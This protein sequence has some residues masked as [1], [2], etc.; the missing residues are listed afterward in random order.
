MN[1]KLLILSLLAA[2]SLGV[3]ACGDKEGGSDSSGSAQQQESSEP[4][5]ITEESKELESETSSEESGKIE[6]EE[7]IFSVELTIPADFVGEQTQEDLDK[8]SEENGFK[9][10]VLN[11]DGSATYTMTKKQHEDM[12]S[13]MKQQLNASLEELI[14]S[15]DYPNFTKIE[16]NDNFTEFT[17][18]TK[19][20][21]LDMA[22]SFSV[23]AFYMYGGMY[24]VFSGDEV[25]NINV[26]FINEST[27]KLIVESNSKDLQSSQSGSE[28]KEEKAAETI[29][30]VGDKLIE[31]KNWY[32][33]KIWNNFVDFD[34]YRET[35]K[36]C[37]G[38][39][40]DI[41]FAYKKFLEAY[42]LKDEYNSYIDLLS[43]DYENLKSVWAKMDEQIKKI[44][45]DLEENGLKEGTP[46][47]ELD[48]LRQYSES[49]YD[50]VK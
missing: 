21:E 10:V 20:T 7:N 8:I 45:K 23:M 26:K 27:G 44:Y 17:I 34:S 36:D 49:F 40:I 29:D 50:Y 2:L 38:S 24:N 25:D 1:R 5:S 37:T 3:S 30:N 6:V 16:A 19:S 4:S 32:V 9:S 43:D 13:E 28:I 46:A 42:S 35:G 11:E 48:L 22:E 41:E 12:L 15:E 47:L 33:S 18:T 14:G 39:E 31:I